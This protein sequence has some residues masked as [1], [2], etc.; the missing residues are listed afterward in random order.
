MF[1]V[2]QADHLRLFPRCGDGAY[3]SVDNCEPIGLYILDTFSVRIEMTLW[4][5]LKDPTVA[6]MIDSEIT[7]S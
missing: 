2:D 6:L 4:S 1:N 7:C 3:D 5:S